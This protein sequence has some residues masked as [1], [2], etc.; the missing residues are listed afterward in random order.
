MKELRMAKAG[1]TENILGFIRDH[2]NQEHIFVQWPELFEYCHHTGRDFITYALAV[3]ANDGTILG[4]CGFILSNSTPSPDVWVALWKVIPSG[5]PSLG[6]ELLEFVREAT[7]CR[8]FCCCGIHEKVIKL[9]RFLGYQTGTLEHYYRLADK[10][11]YHIASVRS[12]H[13]PPLSNGPSAELVP[14]QTMEELLACFDPSRYADRKPYKDAAY[15]Q[16]RYYHHISYRYQVYGVGKGHA[17]LDSILI[18]R[19]V[20]ANGAKALRIVDFIGVLEDFALI[21]D[22][23]RRLLEIDGYEYADCYQRGISEESMKSVGMVKRGTDDLN[24]IPNYFE[25][26]VRENADIHFFTSDMDGF[27]MFKA[28]GDQ[29]RPNIRPTGKE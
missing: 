11:Q 10:P 7:K 22:G 29:D 26:F 6:L 20:S 9:Y 19:A 8:V 16:W 3:N 24:M 1:D 5:S 13:I 4:V 21:A 17:G 15:I 25:P 27:T 12:K 23:L 2:W 14:L 28:D 18:T